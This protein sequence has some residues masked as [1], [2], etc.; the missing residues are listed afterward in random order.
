[1]SRAGRLMAML[2]SPDIHGSLTYSTPRRSKRRHV[3][4]SAIII[5]VV[6][7]VF[8][9]KEVPISY[10]FLIARLTGMNRDAG[11]LDEV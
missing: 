5:S 4:Y 8:F 7:N 10:Y 6:L 1:M 3:V 2:R 11:G 9:S